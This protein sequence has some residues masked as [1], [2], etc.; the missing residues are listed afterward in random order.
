[1]SENTLR[2][3]PENTPS[4]HSVHSMWK[5]CLE[6]IEDE[7]SPQGYRTWLRPIIPV[8][9]VENHLILRVPSQFFFEWLETH[10]QENLSKNVRKVFGR[11]AKIEYLIASG[12]D[13]KP[14]EI[15]FADSEQSIPEITEKSE[16]TD[17]ES[18]L[19]SRYLFNNYFV[20]NDN[21]LALRAAQMVAKHPG[22]TDF[23]P[24]FIYGESG[25]GKTHLL[26]AIGN[27]ISENKKRKKVSF[28][29]S[30]NFINQYIFA[31]QNKKL[32]SFNQKF[33]R[34]DVLLI[35]D[36]QFLSNKKKSQEGL[37]YFF[38]EMERNQKQIVI[39]ADQ[40]PSQLTFLDKRLLSFFQKGL[41]ID[42]IPPG[43]ETR[44]LFI[45]SY[46]EKTSLSILPEVREFLATSLS[47]GMQEM[48]AI[49]I[50]IA[51]QTSLLGKAVALDATQKMLNHIDANWAKKNS[52]LRQWHTV[53]VDDIVRVVSEYL[54]IPID[55]L[56]GYSRQRE[57]TF[58]RQV[59]IYLAKE[60][61]GESLKVIGYH[62]NDRHYT[63]ILHSYK[64]I[65]KEMKNNPA[66]YNLIVDI[67][68]KLKT[69]S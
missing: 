5:Q 28:L 55:I 52:R 56:I 47:D 65:S 59:A 69:I 1:M 51:A 49:M 68:N 46:C 2:S 54:N 13:N 25:C 58:A 7:I 15:S 67:K 43:Y 44:Q 9:F 57:I 17:H 42:L 8:S 35:D 36:I 12:V 21:E 34:T 33:S 30:E 60:M 39:T 62:F 27:Y 16:K 53:K 66:I 64:R 50:R 14:E 63:A 31:L 24:L 40:P 6:L 37:F 45:Q 32:E 26:H 61:S 18:Q 38:S 19:D 48:R 11:S 4:D 41:I 3:R 20:K 22:K 10:Y 29:T 23:N